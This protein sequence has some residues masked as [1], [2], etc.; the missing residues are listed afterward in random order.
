MLTV[1][2]LALAEVAARAADPAPFD[3][4]PTGPADAMLV[5]QTVDAAGG[6]AKLL[7]LFRMKEMLALGSDPEK[8]GNPRT[9]VVE[10][11]GHWWAGTKDRVTVDKEPAV[12]LVWAWTLGALSDAK[13]KLETLPDVRHADRDLYGIQVEGSITPS[14]KLYFD[15]ATKQL[16]VIVWRDSRHEFSDWKTTDGATY[17]S[18]CIGYKL[19][20]GNCWYNTTILE[21]ERLAELPKELSRGAAK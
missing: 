1:A 20:T 12:F 2:C 15:R 16:A 14:M 21:I 4:K 3:G 6:E 7:R 17:P 19:A 9:T 8:K 10:P 13:S 11:P 5:K 18:R